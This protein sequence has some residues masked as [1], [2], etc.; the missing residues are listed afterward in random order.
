MNAQGSLTT[1]DTSKLAS[2]FN[3]DLTGCKGRTALAYAALKGHINASKVLLCKKANANQR[4]LK[5]FIFFEPYKLAFAI[6]E[7]SLTLFQKAIRT[8]V[9]KLLLSEKANVNQ[10]KS[11]L[12]I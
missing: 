12:G 11:E 9:V 4:K 7:L 10:R 1:L 3:I 5:L 2:P 6:T 8:F